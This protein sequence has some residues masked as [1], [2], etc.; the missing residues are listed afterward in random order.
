MGGWGWGIWFEVHG[1]D[2]MLGRWSLRCSTQ[3]GEV[4][5]LMVVKEIQTCIIRMGIRT[6]QS[7]YDYCNLNHSTKPPVVTTFQLRT[8]CVSSN[9]THHQSTSFVLSICPLSS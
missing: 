1:Q 7:T 5:G 3:C 2:G 8:G 4:A 6:A 9:S